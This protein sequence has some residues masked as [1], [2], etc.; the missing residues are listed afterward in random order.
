MSSIRNK[1]VKMYKLLK[2][3]FNEVAMRRKTNSKENLGKFNLFLEECKRFDKCVIVGNG[4]SL[5]NDDL[6]RINGAAIFV[7]NKF[8]MN[9]S[10]IKPTAYFSQDPTVMDQFSSEINSYDDAD[11]SFQ[12]ME[13]SSLFKKYKEKERSVF[14]RVK[15]SRYIR[16]KKP[17]VSFD[18]KKGYADAYSVTGSMLQIAIN[19]GFKTILMIGNDFNYTIVN[20]KIDQ[21]SYPEEMRKDVKAGLPNVEYTYLFYNEFKRKALE[22]GVDVINISRKTKLDVF[23]CDSF[24]NWF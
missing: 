1:L 13:T 24:D 2:N 17:V 6:K 21:T 5:N 4:P 10:G 18:I 12:N 23:R 14:Y 9:K 20:G 19:A 22:K 7:C 15:R 16:R 3:F 8:F 11:F